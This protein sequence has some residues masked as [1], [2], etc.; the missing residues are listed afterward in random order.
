LFP[1][2]IWLAAATNTTFIR[3]KVRGDG[4][5]AMT[6]RRLSQIW[7]DLALHYFPVDCF[8]GSQFGGGGQT[9]FTDSRLSEIWQELAPHYFPADC[10]GINFFQT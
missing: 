2:S 1:F 8:G 4:Q 6:F 10:F 7:R 9:I 5:I 3:S